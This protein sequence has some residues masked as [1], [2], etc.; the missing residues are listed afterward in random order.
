MPPF[1]ED[2]SST[3]RPQT[4]QTRGG[5]PDLAPQLFEFEFCKRRVGVT[6]TADTVRQGFPAIGPLKFCR[7]GVSREDLFMPISR[8]RCLLKNCQARRDGGSL[9][10]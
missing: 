7:H 9:V 6:T 10:I 5:L 2:R 4:V 1:S 8:Q 3:W